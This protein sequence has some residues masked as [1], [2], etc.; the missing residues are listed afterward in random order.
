MESGLSAELQFAEG[1][2]F[3][4]FP[5][6]PSWNVSDKGY[7]P[8]DHVKKRKKEKKKNEDSSELEYLRMPILGKAALKDM[9][10]LPPRVLQLY[11]TE[12]WSTAT[13]ERNIIRVP[14]FLFSQDVGEPCVQLRVHKTDPVTKETT[15]ITC[16]VSGDKFRLLLRG[17]NSKLPG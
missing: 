4:W 7:K 14:A 16:T 1:T 12:S 13:S 8:T 6:H 17:K 10:P 9:K 15:P 5:V 3:E 2:C 11:C